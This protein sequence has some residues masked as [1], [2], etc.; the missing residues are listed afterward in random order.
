MTGFYVV[1]GGMYYEGGDFTTLRLFDS[2]EVAD[3]Y[4]RKLT[5]AGYD[6]AKIDVR[7]VCSVATGV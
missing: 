4:S 6:Y 2:L 3:A 1:I 5:Q 7:E